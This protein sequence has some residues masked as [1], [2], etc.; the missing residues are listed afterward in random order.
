MNKPIH[1]Q[2]DAMR[3]ELN[4]A[5]NFAQQLDTLWNDCE[6]DPDPIEIAPIMDDLY[7]ALNTLYGM[8]NNCEK[9]VS[10]KFKNNNQETLSTM[11]QTK[12]AV[13]FE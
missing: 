12:R 3:T 4:W 9:D 10:D 5:S 13:G 6:Y 1:S 7:S 2:F 11:I 8:L